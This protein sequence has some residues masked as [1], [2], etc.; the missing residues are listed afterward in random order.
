MRHIVV[1]GSLNMDLVTQA[2]RFAQPGETILGQ[3]FSTFLGG[4]GANQAVAAAR[5]GARVSLIGAVGDDAF[6]QTLRQG[7]QNEGVQTEAVLTLADHHT[8]TASIT[9][10]EADNHIIVVPG[11]NHALTPEHISAQASLIKNADV[12]LCQLEIPL[13]TVERAAQICKEANTAFILNPAPAQTLP[14]SLYAL[15]D[16][17]T[18][19]EHELAHL[20]AP[21]SFTDLASQMASLP[22]P[23]IMTHGTQGAYY[24]DPTQQKLIHQPS[25]T[26]TAID[27][28]GAGDTFNAAL[29]VYLNEGLDVAVKKA[30]AA[31]AL[32]VTK[33]GAQAGMPTAAQL[34]EFLTIDL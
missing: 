18:P 6:G 7:L 15:I 32:A 14:A 16:Y 19:N 5:L 24:V 12:V 26:V 34:N 17:L 4:K 1:I 20:T 30:C 9:V 29:A 3:Q 13:S 33:L 21:P 22:C 27:S 8:G 23:V 11:A 28:T 25:F 31:G 2:P 10:A